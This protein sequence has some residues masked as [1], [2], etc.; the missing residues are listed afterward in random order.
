MVQVIKI[1]LAPKGRA[2]V[3]ADQCGGSAL[4]VFCLK[5]N[6]WASPENWLG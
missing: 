1:R 3:D 4:L 5:T 2:S 6:T